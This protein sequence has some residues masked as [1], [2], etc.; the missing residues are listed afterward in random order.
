MLRL[1]RRFPDLR[2]EGLI[3]ELLDPWFRRK[4]L[5]IGDLGA[6]IHHYGKLDGDRERAKSAYYLELTERDAADH[7][8]DPDRQFHLMVQAEVAGDWEKALAAGLAFT[9]ISPE[10]P[11]AVRTTL[12]VASQHLGRHQEAMDQLLQ[13]LREQPD[14]LLALCR[15]PISLEALGRGAEGLPCLDRAIIA[16]PE[17]PMPNLVLCELEEKAGRPAQAREAL[18]AAIACQPL[19]P[20]LRQGLVD[21]DLRHQMVAQAAA[22]AMEA[23]RALPDQGGG[24]WHALA[25]GFLLKAGHARPGQAVLDLGLAAFPE[26]A[27]LRALKAAVATGA[28]ATGAPATAA[29]GPVKFNMGCGRDRRPGYTNVDQSSACAPDQVLDLEVTPWPWPNDCAEEV[30]FNHSLEHLGGD[31]KVFLAIMKELYRVCRDGAV[32]KITV[33]HPRHDNFI[34]DPTHVRVISPQVMSLFSRQEND[35]WARQGASNTP[36]AHYLGVDFELTASMVEL[37]EPYRT[38]LNQGLLSKEQVQTALKE[39][40]NVGVEFRMELTVRKANR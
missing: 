36:L 7:P 4:N 33:P 10:V 15:L 11:R 29:G 32:V 25:A 22:D 1:F 6:V 18:R 38:Q 37:D 12:A 5:P 23:L 19:N 28:P 26:H 9:R 24:Q 16:H 30:V 17:N 40:N 39:K 31:P 21:L 2:F 14:H 3:H 8:L 35:R 34:G 27:S 13:V 20:R